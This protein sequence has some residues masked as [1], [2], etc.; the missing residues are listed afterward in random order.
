MSRNI[1]FVLGVGALM[2]ASSLIVV[3]KAHAALACQREQGEYQE[4]YDVAVLLCTY[5]EDPEDCDLALDELFG[6]KRRLNQCRM[7]NMA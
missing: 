1:Y 7:R 4:A 3:D 2:L 5:S 6:A